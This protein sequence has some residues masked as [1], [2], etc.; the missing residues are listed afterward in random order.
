MIRINLLGQARPKASR[1]SV[2]LEATFQIGM[3]ALAL[4]V[5]LGALTL[6]WWQTNSKVQDVQ[7]QINSL[8]QQKTELDQI[9]QQVDDFEKQKA[10]LQQRI[11]VIEQLQRNRNG[12]QE[13]LDAVA[14]TVTRTE[15]LWL[16][17]FG[18]K[19]DS[20][21]LIG[22]AGSINAVAEFITQL[23]RSGYFQQVDI[24]DTH[25]DENPA[26]QLYDFTINVVFAPPGG[27]TAGSS[28]PVQQVP[29]QQAPAPAAVP[30][31]PV[32]STR[33]G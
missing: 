17:S 30:H 28:A 7:K 18:R 5:A 21:T 33:K 26:V 24:K 6:D 12:G 31:A 2:P 3:F 32:T 9:K 19:G 4:A 8:K 15:T 13:L 20:I 14:N 1:S 10:L 29:V 27:Q 22:T 11:N 16:T 23:R 25:Q